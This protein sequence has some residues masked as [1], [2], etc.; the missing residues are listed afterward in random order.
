M[1]E[2]DT[3]AESSR[4]KAESWKTTAFAIFVG[5]FLLI[6]LALLFIVMLAVGVVSLPLTYVFHSVVEPNQTRRRMRAI[7]RLMDESEC[8]ERLGRGEGTLIVHQLNAV[9][10]SGIQDL[11]WYTDDVIEA[12]S[13]PEVEPDLDTL[14]DE[15]ARELGSNA[16]V[17]DR[18]YRK[19]ARTSWGTSKLVRA[20]GA[21]A[22]A[23]RVREQCA[24]ARV[25]TVSRYRHLLGPFEMCRACQYPLSDIE[26]LRCPE[27]G[28]R[29]GLP[30]P[31]R[32]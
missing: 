14:T 24:T 2:N 18:I 20:S 9:R 17:W 11:A 15:Q 6:G 26:S 12:P 31:P 3:K 32:R 28:K 25:I 5:P 22:F 10:F 21:M 30:R 7:G 16:V 29:N 27:C 13:A 23:R 19:Y 1:G 4:G 8:L